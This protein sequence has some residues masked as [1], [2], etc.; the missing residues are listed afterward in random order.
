[1]S[2][3]N[4][5][6]RMGQANLMKIIFHDGKEEELIVK[7]SERVRE[8]NRNERITKYNHMFLNRREEKKNCFIFECIGVNETDA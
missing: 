1:M 2:E 6:S 7:K 3:S 4:D 8:R 5:Y